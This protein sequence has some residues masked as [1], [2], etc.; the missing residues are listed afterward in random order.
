MLNAELKN[1][2]EMI[3]KRLLP[4]AFAILFVFMASPVCGQ[5]VLYATGFESSEG[6][7]MGD[8]NNEVLSAYGP[9]DA[10]WGTICGTPTSTNSYLISGNQSMALR[11]Y[12][13]KK[14]TP[15]CMMMF[16]IDNVSG[17]S[18]T[19]KGSRTG[20]FSVEYSVDGG[21]SWLGR[22][23][24]S[25]RTVVE[26]FQY[27]VPS[28]VADNV[29]FKISWLTT[30]NSGT[31]SIDDLQILG[32][33]DSRTLTG[34]TFGADVDGQTFT[35]TEGE[36]TG[37]AGY[38]AS[39]TPANAGVP[40]YESS[41]C[42]VVSVDGE[43]GAVSFGNAFGKATITARFDGD[44]LYRPS[45]A[46]YTVVYQ[47][48]P[49]DEA[50]IFYESFDQC[51]SVGGNDG[52]WGGSMPGG[53]V[54]YD[55]DGDWKTANA[56][57]YAACRCVRFGTASDGG[58]LQTPPLEVLSGDGLLEFMA[59]AWDGDSEVLTLEISGGGE[60]QTNEIKMPNASWERFYVKIIGGGPNT[61]IKF[62]GKDKKGRF[63][64]DEIKVVPADVIR[65]LSIDESEKSE[66]EKA[67]YA[68]VTL[69]RTLSSEYWNTFCVPFS[70]P[71]DMIESIFGVGTKITEFSGNMEDMSMVFVDAD[72]IEAG[73]PY[74]IKP[75]V[76]VENPLFRG[77]SI[78]AIEPLGVKTADGQYAFTGVYG[79]TELA[80][81]GTN[82]F[83]STT[84]K[85]TVPLPSGNVINGLRAYITIP[86]SLSPEHATLKFE[87]ET[88]GIDT[89]KV[90]APP[91]RG[92][93]SL[94]GRYVG[95]S[96]E[97][98]SRGIY[99]K[100]GKKIVIR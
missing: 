40:V 49:S 79:P 93:Y 100:E 17:I 34:M 94:D 82:L 2:N 62:K 60:L 67:V 23:E 54:V 24:F 59:G 53:N 28:G 63:F 95:D 48:K 77:V 68:D 8:Y 32:T 46:S 11:Y 16:S 36:E 44:S 43:T 99:I 97:V 92:F 33:P 75:G 72:M 74:L 22:K 86:S 71:S 27:D 76:D 96:E 1:E 35:V 61:R 90:I 31:L 21:E 56:Q 20:S 6:F 65:D 57:S 78:T 18:F 47:A 26:T 81:D 98:L 41:D 30:S 89:V 4:L 29:R 38:V 42:N 80:T 69:T 9:D 15:Y 5:D 7:S 91:R 88:T 12:T 66:I 64:L 87:S 25:N 10:R 85:L 39:L 50:A 73:K 51:E 55:N 19:A 83:I 13:S 14:L 84:G 58:W 52:V 70:V 45:S 3:G 37:F